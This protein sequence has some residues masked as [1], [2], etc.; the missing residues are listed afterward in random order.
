MC[1][2]VEGGSGGAVL[3]INV[4]SHSFPILLSLSQPPPLPIQPGPDPPLLFPKS[5]NV[6][7]GE[8]QFVERGGPR[9]LPPRCFLGNG[10]CPAPVALPKFMLGLLLDYP[11]SRRHPHILTTG[12]MAWASAGR[13]PELPF[14]VT[15]MA[16]ATAS[17]LPVSCQVEEGKRPVCW[18]LLPTTH[19]EAQSP[20]N[21]GPAQGSK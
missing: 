6:L 15:Q 21:L 20:G 3:S 5:C 17:V 16:H 12:N 14:C 4:L 19:N 9:V 13:R 2:A 8:T 10:D 18:Q 7:S 11:A 1:A